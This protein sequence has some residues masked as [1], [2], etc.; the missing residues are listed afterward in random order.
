M[1]IVL[2]LAVLA[3]LMVAEECPCQPVSGAGYRLLAASSGMMLVVLFA[4][5]A[6]VVIAKRLRRD[7]A[8]RTGLL[9]LF[10]NLRRL[11]TVLWL[12]VAGGIIYWL[13]WAQLVRFN[14]RLDHAILVDELLILTPVLLPLV[15]SWAAFYEV[16]RAIRIGSAGGNSES[17]LC[18]RRQ[19]LGLHLRHYMG[20][21]LLPV[22]GLLVVQDVAE[23]LVPGILDTGYAAA[24]CVP[25]VVL[26]FVMFP[27]LLR[28]IWRT[29]PLPP[30]ALRDRLQAAARRAGFKAREILVWHTGGMVVNA[31]VAGFI[32]SLRYV[33]LTDGLI[34]Q[35]SEEEMEAVFGHEIGHVRHRHLLLRVLAML[36]PLSLWIMAQQAFPQA[37]AATQQW[38]TGAGSLQMP[39]GLFTLALLAVYVFLAFGTYSRVLEAQADLFGCRTLS[40]GGTER[41]TETFIAALEK[42]A[43][44]AGTNRRAR[45]WQHG[46]IARRVDFLNRVSVDPG[47]ELSFRLKVGLLNGLMICVVLSPLVFQ[48][49]LG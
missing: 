12:A 21:L 22:L 36:A 29:S 6:S 20:I 5:V 27:N 44:T 34:T 15:L 18:T 37:V 26:V 8:G 10:K 28:R 47:S 23:L 38:I 35:L 41:P 4:T 42:L 13:D 16:D 30:G 31:A 19:Y 48:L 9:R 49:L 45:S 24:V 25:P 2:I 33:F 46:S 1:Q 43:A 7:F 39:I 32:P 14:W 3:T 11:H 40:S 17:K